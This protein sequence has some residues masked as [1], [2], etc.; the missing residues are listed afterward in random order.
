VIL[1]GLHVAGVD[2]QAAHARAEELRRRRD[3]LIVE[4]HRMG[5][6]YRQIARVVGLT[7]GRVHQIVK[8]AVTEKHGRR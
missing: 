6:G 8:G 7:P 2:C 3:A 1:D 5:F 4:A